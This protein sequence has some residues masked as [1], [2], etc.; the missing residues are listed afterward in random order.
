MQL[1]SSLVCVATLVGTLSK[2]ERQH[3]CGYSHFT[4]GA[5][6]RVPFLSGGSIRG[7]RCQAV[8]YQCW[9]TRKIFLHNPHIFLSISLLWLTCMFLLLLKFWWL[10]HLLLNEMMD[11]SS[12]KV[13]H[14]WNCGNRAVEVLFESRTAQVSALFHIFIMCTFCLV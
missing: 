12:W 14:I 10:R 1:L 9:D 3:Q 5:S 4:S 7:A 8:G 2:W 6:D 11:L 13:G